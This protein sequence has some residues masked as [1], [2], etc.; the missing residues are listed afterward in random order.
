VKFEDNEFKFFNIIAKGLE[1]TFTDTL[2]VEKEI[3]KP[4]PFY[5]DNWFWTSIITIIT[6]LFFAFLLVVK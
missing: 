2:L 1:R 4:L 5:E 6:T 3:T